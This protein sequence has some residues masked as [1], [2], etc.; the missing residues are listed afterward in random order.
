MKYFALLGVLLFV[1][2]C[3]SKNGHAPV[4]DTGGGGTFSTSVGGTRSVS[5][6]GSGNAGGDL[7]GGGAA[8]EAG[9]LGADSLA[10]TVKITSPQPVSDPNTGAV[11]TGNLVQVLCDVAAAS[12]AGATIDTHTVKIEAFD[13]KGVALKTAATASTQNPMDANEYGASVSLVGVPNGPVSFACSVADKSLPAKTTSTTVQTFYDQGP[14][15]TVANPLPLSSFSLKKDVL[16]KFSVTAVPLDSAD[17]LAAVDVAPGKVTLRV[18][19]QPIDLS[20]AQDPKD[21]TTYSVDVKLSDP[22]QFPKTPTGVVPVEISAWNKRPIKATLPYTFNIDGTPPVIQIVS[23]TTG[24]VVGGHVTLEFTVT[25][26]QSGVDPNSISIVLNGLPPI[27]F[28]GTPNSG[29]AVSADGKTFDY[30][31]DS[32]S[33]DINGQVQVHVVIQASDKATNAAAGATEDLYLDNHAPIVDLDPPQLRE[34]KKTGATT[35]TCSAPFDPLGNSPGDATVVLPAGIYRAL[36]WDLTNG[37]G[38]LTVEHLAG[39]DPT[40]VVLYAQSDPAT[41]LLIAKHNT[42]NICDDLATDAAAKPALED[43]VPIAP[44]GTSYFPSSADPIVG[45]CTAGAD[46]MPPNGLCAA[47]ASDLTRVIDHAVVGAT[48][49]VIYSLKSSNPEECTGQ[50]WVLVDSGL[51]NGWVCIAALAKDKVGNLGISAPLRVCLDDPK[52]TAPACALSST[53][54]PTCTDGCI[55]P[56]HFVPVSE[57][58]VPGVLELPR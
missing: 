29:W 30:G 49:S 48:E 33:S 54:P 21:P 7:A 22:I 23:P 56:G 13:A 43:L 36:V 47:N 51:P 41:P 17:K 11:V 8:G 16:F 24:Q 25:D 42:K 34:R 58:G 57:T 6:G 14:T 27:P 53:T 40:S 38:G 50:N 10:P 18:D 31:F 28:D 4:V 9:A 52:K 3:G 19:N 35:F 26:S 37:I 20:A 32:N 2:A 15:I 5:H 45:T 55:P 39:T 44:T 12:A 46:G 1:V